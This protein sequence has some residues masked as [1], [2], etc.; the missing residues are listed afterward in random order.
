MHHLVREKANANIPCLIRGKLS[1]RNWSTGLEM[2]RWNKGCRR[3]RLRS[4]GTLPDAWD[5]V[6]DDDDAGADADAVFAFL[7]CMLFFG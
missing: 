2:S 4:S 5:R 3:R 7:G 1:V 6:N